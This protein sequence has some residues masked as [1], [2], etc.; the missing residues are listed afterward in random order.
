MPAAVQV[1]VV[2]TAPAQQSCPEAPHTAHFA[3]VLSQTNGVPQNVSPPVKPSQQASPRPPHEA[4]VPVWQLTNGAV[5]LVVAVVV[6]QHAWPNLPQ[7]PLLH[8]PAVH[9]PSPPEQV[10]A[11]AMHRP[12]LSQQAPAPEQ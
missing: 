7:V 9:V 4:Q 8:P 3:V 6:V 10:P 11:A 2:Q 12:A 5:Q 1:P